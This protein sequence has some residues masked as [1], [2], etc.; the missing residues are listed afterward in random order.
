MKNKGKAITRIV[1]TVLLIAM[2]TLAFS[3]I[4]GYALAGDTDWNTETVDNSG[5]VGW[6][7]FTALQPF[8]ISEKASDAGKFRCG[9]VEMR[10]GEKWVIIDFP[11]FPC[12]VPTLK[13]NVEAEDKDEGG[14]ANGH[15]DH[16]GRVTFQILV[17]CEDNSVAFSAWFQVHALVHKG[18]E[19]IG[20]R[21]WGWLSMLVQDTSVVLDV[22]TDNLA[23]GDS[24]EYRLIVETYVKAGVMGV[25]AGYEWE[26]TDTAYV[27]VVSRAHPPYHQEV[28][29][30]WPNPDFVYTIG[31][32][33]P[34]SASIE[35]WVHAY[36]ENGNPVS[37]EPSNTRLCAVLAT[38]RGYGTKVYYTRTEPL[39]GR[40]YQEYC[41]DDPLAEGTLRISVYD[42]AKDPGFKMDPDGYVVE[43]E[44]VNPADANTFGLFAVPDSSVAPGGSA[45]YTIG[46]VP[47]NAFEGLVTLSVSDLP[48]GTSYEFGTNPVYVHPS[49]TAQGTIL[50]ISPADYT[51]L[52]L[53]QF[54]I[55]ATH[56]TLTRDFICPLMVAYRCT[57]VITKDEPGIANQLYVVYIGAGRTL[58]NVVI[59][60]N[61]NGC[62]PP[63]IQTTTGR[64][65]AIRLTWPQACVDP[66]EVVEYEFTVDYPCETVQPPYS[67]TWTYQ[68]PTLTEWGLI[69][70]VV[71]IVFSAWVVLRRRRAVVSRQ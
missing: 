43:L 55:S 63:T 12:L 6:D 49:D 22:G 54:K 27:T 70:L 64:G 17:H 51:P 35:G 57:E 32:S 3:I 5:D 1:F 31:D 36:D 30:D 4:G 38:E 40:F 41:I 29:I 50:T 67:V 11:A 33:G 56:D 2:V 28:T 48:Q 16:L 13:S 21:P 8:S 46:L 26:D 14:G 52:G 71:L 23:I 62:D 58:R 20:W 69:V 15:T 25:P 60:S 47:I 24:A 19:L 9:N 7:S 59:T 45:L 10:L 37:G 53:H 65:D 42:D 44:A 34:G 39:C 68:F 66:G 61:P 18:S